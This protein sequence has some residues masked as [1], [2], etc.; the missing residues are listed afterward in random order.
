MDNNGTNTLFINDSDNNRNN[1]LLINGNVNGNVAT[2]DLNITVNATVNNDARPTFLLLGGDVDLGSG[3]ITLTGDTDDATLIEVVKTDGNQTINANIV[4]TTD[5]IGGRLQ[6]RNVAN[7]VT[8]NGTIGADGTGGLEDIFV[9]VA[10][11][12]G[13]AIF[14]G[15]VDAA[16]IDID[17]NGGSSRADFNEDV[18]GDTIS[19]EGGDTN[20]EDALAIF[21]GNVNVTL[22]TLDDETP[23][24]VGFDAQVIFGGNNIDINSV[25][26]T[27]TGVNDGRG[28]V[29]VAGA[30]IF[31]SAIGGGANDVEIIDLQAFTTFK[32]DV[33]T[34]S[35]VNTDVG[36]SQSLGNIVLLDTSLNNVT[37]TANNGDIDLNGALRTSGSNNASVVAASDLSID[38]LITPALSAF[39]TLTLTG[40]NS[41]SIGTNSDTTITAKS[42]IVTGSNAT[43]GSG[44]TTTTI[45]V[46]RTEA[47][48]PEI[49]PVIDATGDVITIDG[50]VKIGLD[51]SELSFNVGD[52]VTVINSDLNATTSYATL[53]G[54]ET[55]TFTDTA[56][57]DL[58]DNG[59]GAQD[60]KFIIQAKE[61]IDGVDG[62]KED[63]LKNSLDAVSD[64]DQARNALFN[65]NG[66][67]TADA[68]LELQNDPTGGAA[69]T[70]VSAGNMVS[71]FDL[72]SSRLS[73]LRRSGNIGG[74][75]GASSG[76][77]YIDKAA[78][79]RGFGNTADQDM[80][81]GVQGYDSNT[82]GAMAGLDVM[83]ENDIR[84][85]VNAS[86]AVTDI[87][88]DGAGN[89][90]TDI[91]TYR[92]GA[93]GGKDFERFYVE[94]QASFAYNDIKTSRNITFGGLNRTANGDTEGYEYGA[95]IGAGMPLALDDRQT[96]TS[97][98][99]FQYIHAEVDEF[100]ETGAGALNAT[101]DNEDIDVAE[102]AIG[103]KYDAD[104]NYDVGTLTPSL[105]L[106]GSYDFIGDTAV[107][108]QTFTGGGST[109]RV[110]GADPAQFSINYGAGISWA[111]NDNIWEVSLNYD[112]K[113][114]SDY[115][116][117]GAR[118]EAKY[119]F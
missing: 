72:V 102:L 50:S 71:G 119:R 25:T 46:G 59:S 57:L 55:I 27:I 109:F 3:T 52:T 78:W 79:L 14:N 117:H 56:L 111:N 87:E 88:T 20:G 98:V 96:L 12:H 115:I 103:A 81:D 36:I 26:G 99:D 92:I 18:T 108:N 7:T 82:V 80:R 1:A 28:R 76:D 65:L 62:D 41:L 34:Q 42:Q 47:F 39:K 60:L 106:S 105:R 63:T 6:I 17:A 116:S 31:N 66:S 32:A 68:A 2:N 95:R 93:Y 40:T 24:G 64:D 90:E 74:Q 110:E 112:G 19:I 49:T 8:F 21:R 73:S 30:T 9:G 54:D 58:E 16:A 70:Q 69:T 48:L 23:G 45:N 44:G 104:I 84:L 10:G 91:D 4:S 15:T 13:N 85:G 83:L 113:T 22:I 43:I 97:I 11:A 94:G 107:S 5:D 35:D 89:H 118:I 114:K 100:T 38:G 51:T 77:G 61:D 75:T 29:C 67:L 101:V 53:I 37:L 86:Y 33:S